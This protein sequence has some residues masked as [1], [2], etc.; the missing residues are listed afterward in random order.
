M[1]LLKCSACPRG[2]FVGVPCPG[3]SSCMPCTPPGAEGREA[4][5]SGRLGRRPLSLLK[6][7]SL[8]P[9][10]RDVSWGHAPGAD[11]R[12]DGRRS[13]RARAGTSTG[14]P[15]SR[16]GLALGAAVRAVPAPGGQGRVR[17]QQAQG[18]GGVI[19]PR[20]AGGDHE[21]PYRR[22]RRGGGVHDGDRQAAR[23]GRRAL[24]DDGAGGLRPGQGPGGVR[25]HGRREA[26]PGGA[27]R[28]RGR[29]RGRRALREARRR[30]PLQLPAG[31]VQPVH[32]AG[33]AQGARAPHGRLDD[34]LGAASDRP[35]QPGQRGPGRGR[36][37]AER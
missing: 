29:R 8:T 9:A 32:A 10:L 26:V 18:L 14:W 25:P 4:A 11:A 30:R 31:G 6:N 1:L 27:G 24:R 23:P 33:G 2:R 15:S 5:A 21:G 20:E 3:G 34:A 37:R 17:V 28:R 12:S 36:D 35:V 19:R 13:R 7:R 16:I 22:Q